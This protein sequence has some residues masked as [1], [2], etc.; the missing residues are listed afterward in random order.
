M[1]DLATS[2]ENVDGD[3]LEGVGQSGGANLLSLGE[4]RKFS[5]CLLVC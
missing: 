3:R 1:V 5:S 4:I 2:A